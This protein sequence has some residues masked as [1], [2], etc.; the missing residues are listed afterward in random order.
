[1]S[2]PELEALLS[3]FIAKAAEQGVALN[4]R[5]YPPFA[6]RLKP[7]GSGNATFFSGGFA[8]VSDQTRQGSTPPTLG[9]YG[10]VGTLA[11]VDFVKNVVGLYPG[12]AQEA[13]RDP[14]AQRPFDVL[15][16]SNPST[17]DRSARLASDTNPDPTPELQGGLKTLLALG[18]DFTSVAC[19]T[20]HAWFGAMQEA[21][22]FDAPRQMSIV[23]ALA[24]NLDARGIA[25]VAVLATEGTTNAR[26]YQDVLRARGINVI[27][28]TP[29]E[30]G[31]VHDAIYNQLDGIKA[32]SFEGPRQRLLEI[33]ARYP[34]TTL[35]LCCT[36]LGLVLNEQQTPDLVAQN[37]LIDNNIVSPKALIRKLLD[38]LDDN[39]EPPA[40]GVSRARPSRPS[41]DDS[42]GEASALRIDDPGNVAPTATSSYPRLQAATQ[43]AT[44]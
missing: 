16:V 9:V 40:D 37:R 8:Q 25:E 39:H 29:A 32:G 43:R 26:I 33:A 11:G 23:Q 19:N 12:V 34:N 3:D 21:L 15:L 7:D 4:D 20:A 28:L 36:E 10:G 35:A 18:A 38:D 44:D 6:F 30:V 27:D 31:I 5:S 1:M 13:G 24:D 41:G 22:G 14:A 2:V 42:G 17:P